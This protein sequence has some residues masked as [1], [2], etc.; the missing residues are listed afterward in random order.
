MKMRKKHWRDAAIRYLRDNGPAPAR[1]IF[2]NTKT[3]AGKRFIQNGPSCAVGAAQL[4]KTD[5]RVVGEYDLSTTI[6]GH[7]Y[8]VKFWRLKDEEVL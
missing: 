3:K 7:S 4:L 2:E 1:S 8:R 5:P 6:Q